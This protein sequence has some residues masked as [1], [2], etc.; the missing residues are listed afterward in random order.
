VWVFVVLPAV[1]ID[2]WVKNILPAIEPVPFVPI[3]MALVGS[4]VTLFGAAYVYL[5]YRKVVE[6][7]AHPA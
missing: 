7:D 1:L 5:L 2:G 3:I 4:F 6:D